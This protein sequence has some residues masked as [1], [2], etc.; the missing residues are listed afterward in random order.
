MY[1]KIAD[2]F[3]EPL[4]N[5]D[6]YH[7]FYPRSRNT[8][9]KFKED[10]TDEPMSVAITDL[11]CVEYLQPYKQDHMSDIVN[12]ALIQYFETKDNVVNNVANNDQLTILIVLV[13]GILLLQLSMMF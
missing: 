12:E 11:R 6:G 8:K 13:V 2:V 1:A 3:K 5:D 10:T 4:D 7:N 9:V